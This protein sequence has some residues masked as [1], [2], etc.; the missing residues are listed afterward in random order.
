MLAYVLLHFRPFSWVNFRM[1]CGVIWQSGRLV[2]SV[3]YTGKGLAFFIFL[4]KKVAS[5]EL[6]LLHP[7]L[8]H[9][10]VDDDGCWFIASWHWTC[11]QPRGSFIRAKHKTSNHELKSL[12]GGL[13][14]NEVEWNPL[15]KSNKLKRQ[16]S[17]QHA[18]LNSG[19]LQTRRQN[20][21]QHAKLYSGLLQ[22]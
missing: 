5:K 15:R 2:R 3:K 7:D 12:W 18:K 1:C 8:S 22:A 19:L 13:G 4:W 20:S 21:W 14:K 6:F 16:N 11:S 10:S 9:P 17:Q